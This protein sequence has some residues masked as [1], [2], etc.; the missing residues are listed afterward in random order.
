MG[1]PRRPRGP[2]SAWEPKSPVVTDTPLVTEKAAEPPAAVEAMAAPTAGPIAEP[3]AG[4][5][6]ALPPEIA[7]EVSPATLEQALARVTEDTDTPEPD[8][9]A[10][11][12][13]APAAEPEPASEPAPAA[14]EAAVAPEIP[15]VLRAAAN[16][17][18]HAEATGGVAIAAERFDVV[19]IGSTVARYMR[20]EGEAAMAHLRALSGARSPAEIIRL[21]VGE[22]QR[23]AD[24]SLTCWVTVIGKASRI[25][26]FR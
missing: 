7:P 14:A 22:A 1:K 9:E 16:G 25:V 3:T 21:Q 13:A 10:A 8:H 19:E 26:A 4:T 18:V 2:R 5:S 11:A 12:E 23:A 17:N 20:G 24:A 6:T 15:D